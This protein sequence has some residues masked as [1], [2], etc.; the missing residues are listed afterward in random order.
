MPLISSYDLA[1]LDLDGVVYRGEQAVPHA[2]ETI[3]SLQAANVPLAFLTNNASR[4]SA[5][6]AA[7]IRA[8]G[9]AVEASDV[10]T[11]G[12]AIARIVAES[13]PPGSAVLVVGGPGLTVPL[14]VK[15]LRCVASADERPAAVVQG[16]HPDVG[17]RHLAEASY[18]I[19]AGTTWFVSNM[20]RTFPSARGTAP[21]NGALVEA[22]RR[23]TGADPVAVA[24]KPE[25]GL[26]EEALGRTGAKRPL[27]IGD[28]ID[29]DIVGALNCGIDA[30]HVLTGISRL[31]ELVQLPREQRPHFVAPDLRALLQPHPP[32]ER[33]DRQWRCGTAIAEMTADGTVSL[34]AG[35]PD[36]LEAVRAAIDAAWTHLDETGHAP[37][38]T[39]SALEH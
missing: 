12:E 34:A 31:G 25:R 20:D 2:V 1:M 19:Q 7:Q 11:A 5:E 24:G 9:L 33:N 4:T 23:A 8:F 18:A 37:R 38:L 30:V 17:W 13:V 39:G 32:V 6:V 15:G 28:R 14:G 36:S 3:S 35:E 21:G 16:F 27:M 29:T 26:F 10:V 22:V